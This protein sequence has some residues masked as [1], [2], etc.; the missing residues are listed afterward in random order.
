[1]AV[2]GKRS[3]AARTVAGAICQLFRPVN[4]GISAISVLIGAISG[5]SELFSPAIWIAALAAALVT[6]AGNGYNDCKDAEVDRINRPDRPIP[7]GNLA[8]GTALSGS[9]AAAVGGVGLAWYVGP[10]PGVVATAVLGGLWLYSA[11]LKSTLLWGNLLVSALAGA[12]FPY[13][14]LAGG[15]LGRSWIP[16]LFALLFHLGREIIKDIE[17]IPGD[18][19]RGL[20][21]LA[22]A[23]GPRAAGAVSAG[24]YGLLIV[25]TYLPWLLDVYGLAYAV[26][27]SVLNAVVAAVLFRLL[28][29]AAAGR[30]AF[31]RM[32]TGGMP[33]G[34]LAILAGELTRG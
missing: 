30:V 1:M 20:Q 31:S 5:D 15:D 12:V 24:V 6:A 34:L 8:S 17:D 32:L 3:V 27:V 7:S 21:T 29:G 18:R 13:G 14:A 28:S 2:T 33:L 26:P 10:G 19:A 23:L 22:I 11:H 25:A 16:G 4:C 9:I